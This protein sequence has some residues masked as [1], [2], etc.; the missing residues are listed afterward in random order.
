MSPLP[1]ALPEL[2]RQLF[3]CYP[4]DVDELEYLCRRGCDGLYGEGHID[5][6]GQLAGLSAGSAVVESLRLPYVYLT[7]YYRLQDDILDGDLR[8][9]VESVFVAHL[10]SL[11]YRGL[12]GASQRV[13]QQDL[14]P[15]ISLVDRRLSENAAALQLEANLRG[16]V[17]HS[18]DEERH[19]AIGRSNSTFLFYELLCLVAG[20]DRESQV[21]HLLEELVCTMQWG[22]DLGDWEE[23]FRDRNYTHVIQAVFTRLH[24][25]E[26]TLEEMR[27]CLYG[28]GLYEDLV[29]EIART[30]G[31]IESG[32]ARLQNCDPSG[33]IAWTAANKSKA[34]Q[35][36]RGMVQTKVGRLA[37]VGALTVS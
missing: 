18:Y 35:L 31:E 5:I 36:L 15:A 21:V 12:V 16:G 8:F 29:S 34:V 13:G 14:Q 10:L 32:F 1:S 26:P 19:A 23:D 2:R 24:N 9:P 11:F 27:S 37:A 28:T 4:N 20:R 7:A 22:D 25:E 33:A 17:H 6:L 3:D 30:L